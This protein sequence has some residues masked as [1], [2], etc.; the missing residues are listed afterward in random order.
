MGRMQVLFFG[1]AGDYYEIEK[2]NII[3]YG[4]DTWICNDSMWRKFI[5]N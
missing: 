1:K 4:I 3:R 2:I 5:F